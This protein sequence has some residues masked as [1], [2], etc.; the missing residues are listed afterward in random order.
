MPR[1]SQ[2]PAGTLVPPHPGT[3]PLTHPDLASLGW[4]DHFARQIDPPA[5]GASPVSPA[6]LVGVE[7]DHV[8]ALDPARAGGEPLR[9]AVPRDGATNAAA[10]GATDGAIGGGTGGLAVGDWV[11]QDGHRVTR[12]LAPRTEIARRVA[13]DT[14]RRQLI[15]ANVDAL[16]VVTSCN[17]D[18]SPA[19]IE[20]YLAV[21]ASAGCLPLIVLTKADLA[22]DALAA[23]AFRRDAQRLS[24]LAAVLLLDAR[25]GQDARRLDPW[26][27]PGRTLALVGSS[28]VGK[29]TLQNHLTGVEALTQGVREDD[30]K[31]RHTT[32]ARTLRRTLAGGCLIDTPGMRELG[33]VDAAAGVA[34]VFADVEELARG[35]RFR[36]CTHAG[37]PGCAVQAA[38]AS[39]RLDAERVRRHE[40]LAREER[41]NSEALHERH[42][43]ARAFGKVHRQIKPK[44]ERWRGG[45]G[46]WD[47]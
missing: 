30:A 4:S 1:A 3:P 42:A 41:F 47:D 7:R 39:G 19:R 15:V 10:E 24:A 17:A 2:E 34:E 32:T 5:P 35:C 29:T 20:R 45:S 40:K 25:D 11:L 8:I 44:G 16:A 43:R 21:A 13:G 26:C 36:D 27:G 6:R 23:E 22:A 9:L 38:V 37:E 14:S 31:G 46:A 28:G 18:F 33:L 12:R